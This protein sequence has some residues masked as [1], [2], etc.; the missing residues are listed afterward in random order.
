[1]ASKPDVDPISLTKP[2]HPPATSPP[3]R[4]GEMRAYGAAVTAAER[5]VDQ[6]DAERARRLNPSMQPGRR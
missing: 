1:M 2:Q 6:R 4:H 3:A 5:A